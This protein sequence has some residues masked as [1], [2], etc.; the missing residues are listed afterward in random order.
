[1]DLAKHIV[2]AEAARDLDVVVDRQVD[3]LARAV[4]EQEGILAPRAGAL[5]PG[6]ID[7]R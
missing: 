4:G 6:R 7:L 5:E 1:M 3:V 2:V